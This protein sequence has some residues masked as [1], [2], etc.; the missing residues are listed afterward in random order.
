[1]AWTRLF[2]TFPLRQNFA[3]QFFIE[4]NWGILQCSFKTLQYIP[5]ISRDVFHGMCTGKLVSMF[6]EIVGVLWVR[7]VTCRPIQYHKWLVEIS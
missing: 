6:C 4:T 3:A 2:Q 7:S 5:V 1:M